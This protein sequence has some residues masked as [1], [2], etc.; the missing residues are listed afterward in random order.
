MLF[1]AILLSFGLV[2]C[3]DSA[4]PVEGTKE[5]SDLTAEEVYEK[6]LKASEDMKSAEMVMDLTQK[7]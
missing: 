4:D 5:V 2:A 3:Q 6:T 1:T 7:K